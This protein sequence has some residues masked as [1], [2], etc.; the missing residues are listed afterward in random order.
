MLFCQ[1]KCTQFYFLQ[2]IQFQATRGHFL[3]KG[4]KPLFSKS[5]KASFRVFLGANVVVNNQD[6]LVIPLQAVS[7]LRFAACFFSLACTYS[8]T[9]IHSSCLT[10]NI[11]GRHSIGVFFL[12]D[13]KTTEYSESE[14]TH[15]D[16][17]AQLLSVKSI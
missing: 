1:Q 13:V 4:I 17:Q 7:V 9:Q 8:N 5:F 16:H 2:K 14:E 6:M 11:P 3:A 15:K 10:V 12:S